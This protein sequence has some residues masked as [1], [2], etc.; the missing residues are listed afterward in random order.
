MHRQALP[1]VFRVL[2]PACVLLFAGCPTPL[3]NPMDAGADSA[4]VDAPEDAYVLPDV[5][6]PGEP[7]ARYALTGGFFDRPWPSDT[8]LTSS[9]HPNMMGFMPRSGIVGQYLDTIQEEQ[10]GF[11]TMGAVYFRFGA[12]VDVASLPSSLAGSV[13]AD[14]SVQLIALD[15]GV[16]EAAVHHPFVAVW[17]PR[18]TVFWP[19]RTLAIR[20]ADGMPLLPGT[21][22]AAVVTTR[23]RPSNF[24]S[25]ARDTDFT[26]ILNS[27]ARVMSERAVLGPALARLNTLG[28]STESILN[29]AVF[30]TQDPTAMMAQ[31]RD[32]IVA[33]PAPEI[34]TAMWRR[35][36]MAPTYVVSEG[37]Y[38]APNFQA[39][40]SPFTNEGG[41]ILFDAEGH[42]IPQG[43]FQQR[44]ALSV[45]TSAMPPE[46][47]PIILYG[48]GT[49]GDYRSF[50]DD[51]TAELFAG[52]GIAVMGIDALFH[53]TRNPMPMQAPDLVFFNIVN[54]LTARFNPIEAAL[55]HVT[56]GRVAET[57][58]VPEALYGREVRFN[59]SE[60]YY[61]GHSQGALVGPL[62]VAVDDTPRAA[63][64]SA[65]GSMIGH[66]LLDKTEPIDI[67]NIVRAL[68]G[69][70]G[71][72]EAFA[73]EGF[74][75]EHPMI[76]VLQGWID[77]A[78]P[79]NYAP[80]IAQ[81]PRVGFAP[82]S[83]IATEGLRDGYVS[84]RAMEALAVA[85]G[86]PIAEPVAREVPGLTFLGL[87]P[88]SGAITGNLAEGRTGA[89]LQFATQGH[90][91]FFNVPAAR[92]RAS[93]FF[94]S[95]RGGNQGTLP[96][97]P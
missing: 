89:L 68:L 39:G 46:G 47:Y 61:L 36:T 29:L 87:T 37:F 8:R 4:A 90:F 56:Q 16:P 63:F 17:E 12:D 92:T 26:A 35:T 28:V 66:T 41:S 58:V 86:V 80:L 7:V 77:P 5:W 71:G 44:F 81:R 60:I 88:R 51:D 15:E 52:V 72:A 38:T 69:F 6:E 79:G 83:V 18:R 22:Y 42:A 33:L 31:V 10:E 11:G 62:Y 74:T 64:F 73:I 13:A 94:A 49:G 14:A 76:T 93:G 91:A 30:T 19:G 59:T 43:T 48:H 96:A 65:G 78:D 67:P 32:D 2:T 40:T 54:P 3:E 45:P 27:D 85:L 50:I 84:P 82:R 9:G 25:F 20:P 55:D 57:M 70:R 53:G 97:A 24:A 75:L 23:V 1:I 34:P 95:L 21:T